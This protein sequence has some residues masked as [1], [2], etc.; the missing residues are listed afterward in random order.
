MKKFIIIIIIFF[1]LAYLSNFPGAAL[2]QEKHEV[3]VALKLIPVIVVDDEGNPVRGLTKEDF[4]IYE[5]GRQVD[6]SAFEAHFLGKERAIEKALVQPIRAAVSSE[7]AR[8]FFLLFDY[9]QSDL[10]GIKKAK[11][12]GL[13]FIDTLRPEDKISIIAYSRDKGLVFYLFSSVDHQKAKAIIQEL[14]EIPTTKQLKKVRDD[15]WLGSQTEEIERQWLQLKAINFVNGLEELVKIL[16]YVPGNKDIILISGGTPRYYL[17]E[18]RSPP[19]K[20][21]LQEI[22]PGLFD[23]FTD[24]ARS[25]ASAGCRVYAINA[26]G[27]KVYLSSSSW[28]R[29]DDSLRILTDHSGGRYFPNIAATSKVVDDLETL[30]G[31]YYVLGYYVEEKWDG[32]Y[33]QIEV[34]LQG[35]KKEKFRLYYQKG[36]FN[37]RPYAELSDFEKKLDLF[38]LATEGQSAYFPLVEFPS[39][40]F[41]TELK[42]GKGKVYLELNLAGLKKQDF[43]RGQV[44]W[45]IFILDEKGYILQMKQRKLLWSQLPATQLVIKLSLSQGQYKLRTVFRDIKEGQA[46]LSTTW[47]AIPQKDQ[48]IKKSRSI[49]PPW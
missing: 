27:H 29:G 34:K 21:N 14:T 18:S 6:I 41:L 25:L 12:L 1:C 7:R 9:S 19:D 3:T 44:E 49:S 23:R 39:R 8:Q 38:M 28:E 11:Q 46:A 15:S 37:P 35:E 40:A 43:L 2:A 32:R 4:I 36:Y 48:V 10:W 30:T 26:K 13:E 47:I 16:T 20:F 31:S 45:L 24:L 22:K 5:D 42:G 33:H 17:Y